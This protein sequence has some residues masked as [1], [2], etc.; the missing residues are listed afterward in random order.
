MKKNEKGSATVENIIWL[1]LMMLVFASIIQF[2]LIFNAK[3]AVE[4]ASFE[5]ARQATLSSQPNTTAEEVVYSFASGV[6]PGWEQGG[7]VNLSIETLEGVDP[8][9][10][11]KVDV[12]YKVPVF[13]SGILRELEGSPGIY[14]VKGSAEMRMEEKP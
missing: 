8:G 6:L 14:T 9:S 11:V 13:F 1:P 10:P 7:R 3:S 12:F 4:G 2:G 5:A